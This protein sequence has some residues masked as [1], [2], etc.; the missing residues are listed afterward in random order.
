MLVIVDAKSIRDLFRDIKPI[1]RSTHEGALMGWDLS[2]HQL[3]I[4]CRNGATYQRR[5]TVEQSGPYAITVLYRDLSELL[6][7]SGTVQLDLQPLYIGI[8]APS[9]QTTLTQAYGI[10]SKYTP[11]GIDFRPCQSGY[12]QWLQAKLADMGPV[13]KTLKAEASLICYPPHAILKYSTMWLQADFGLFNSS[14]S[15]SDLKAVAN[16]K[17]TEFAVTNEV[18]EFQRRDAILA[19]P[20]TN[21]DSCKGVA[22]VLKNPSEPRRLWGADLVAEMQKFQRAV[23]TGPCTLRF[24][25]DGYQVEVDTPAFRCSKAFGNCTQHIYSLSTYTE[26]LTMLFRLFDMSDTYLTVGSNAI[27]ISQDGLTLLQSVL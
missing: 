6:P 4:T 12:I 22:D 26:Y 3:T 20:R 9:M 1:Y 24:Y 25:T 5:I 11:R 17:P 21:V 14:M 13:A 15:L 16:F 7:G 18:I 8:Q 23:G 10:L 27:S 2:N 19:L